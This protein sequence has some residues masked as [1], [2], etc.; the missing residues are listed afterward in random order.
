[1][2]KSFPLINLYQLKFS[3][4]QQ[5]HHNRFINF[6]TILQTNIIGIGNKPYASKFIKK[7]MVFMTFEKYRVKVYKTVML[8]L[9]IGGECELIQID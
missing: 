5:V 1:M 8:D 4:N 3:S 2:T 7:K 6:R 9:V